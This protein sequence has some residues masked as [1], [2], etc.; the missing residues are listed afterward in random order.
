MLTSSNLKLFLLDTDGLVKFTA[1]FMARQSPSCQ[2]PYPNHSD[3]PSPRM[4]GKPRTVC[5]QSG[6][7]G[8]GQSVIWSSGTFRDKE[9]V[10]SEKSPIQAV[11]S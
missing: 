5:G 7:D 11:P 6:A 8:G 3:S 10:L 2:H 9:D 4:T 1:D